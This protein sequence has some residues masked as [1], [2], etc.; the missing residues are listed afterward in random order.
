MASIK[1][2]LKD[3]EAINHSIINLTIS[4]IPRIINRT[5]NQMTRP[6]IIIITTTS[7]II[8]AV[9]EAVVETVAEAAIG[10]MI[11]VRIIIIISQIQ[12]Q[13]HPCIATAT[14]MI[15]III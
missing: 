12:M 13:I 4:L 1:R 7:I 9:V 6:A 11:K 2:D 15:R 3:Q 14:F 5:I 8:A 10:D